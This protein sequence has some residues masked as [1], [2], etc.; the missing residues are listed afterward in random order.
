MP[1]DAPSDPRR[2]LAAAN[3]VRDNIALIAG[4]VGERDLAAMRQDVMLR[5]AVERAFMAIDAAVRDIPRADIDRHDIPA[6]L[7][8]GFRNMLAHTYDDLLDDRVVLTIR[9]DL[10][11]LDQAISGLIADLTGS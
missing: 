2:I 8:A 1:S 7:I 4:W 3:A 5:Y 11:A 10:P 6:N 9:Q